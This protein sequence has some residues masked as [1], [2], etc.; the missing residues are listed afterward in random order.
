M[1]TEFD[2]QGEVIT[3]RAACNGTEK[4]TAILV[5]SNEGE[6]DV[7]LQVSGS[8]LALHNFLEKEKL[9]DFG[10]KAMLKEIEYC[11]DN[12]TDNNINVKVSVDGKEI[13]QSV[14]KLAKT[15]PDVRNA[16]KNI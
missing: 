13:I 14:A 11:Y 10:W 12:H 2:M 5:L 9:L 7:E 3:R 16:I 1:H 15:S 6:N 4:F 8:Y